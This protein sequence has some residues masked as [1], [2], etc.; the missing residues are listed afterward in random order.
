MP[1][2]IVIALL[3]STVYAI[4]MFYFYMGWRKSIFSHVK[5]AYSD[6]VSV[7]MAVRNEAENLPGLLRALSCQNIEKSDY[8]IIVIDDNSSDHTPDIILEHQKNYPDL[9]L[10]YHRQN[11]SQQGKK[12]ALQTALSIAKHPIIMQIDGDCVPSKDWIAVGRSYFAEAKVQMVLGA[13]NISPYDKFRER[14]QALEL[15]SLIGSGVGAMAQGKPL[16]SNGSNLA[17]RRSVLSNLPKGFYQTRQASG[18]DMFLMMNIAK[19]FGKDAIVYVKDS[20]HTVLTPPEKSW[21]ALWQQRLRWVSK[22]GSYRDG[23]VLFVSFVVFFQNL[24]LLALVP[25]GFIWSVYGIWWLSI[26]L[27]K[28]LVDFVLLR[29]VC[30]FY[31]QSALL[32]YYPLIFLMYPF[33]IVGTAIFGQFLQFDWKG[34]KYS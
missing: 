31:K 25:F 1:I 3:I 27:L 9:Q 26:V 22:S 32:K 30:R 28:A 29:D 18:D 14:F 6:K 34:R 5:T 15:L 20:L 4:L 12:V 33:F 17:F 19:T 24:L 23:F 16:M 13:V 8:E 21:K 10:I 7:I 11:P 2:F